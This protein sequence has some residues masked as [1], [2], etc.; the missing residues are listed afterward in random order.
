MSE[1]VVYS[2]DAEKVQRLMQAY[3]SSVKAEYLTL[4]HRDGSVIAEAGSFRGDPTPLAVLSTASFDSARQIGAMMGGETFQAVSYIGESRSVY[5]SPVD[6]TLILIQI[7]AGR[8]PNR[9]E[10]YN[11]MLVEKLLGAVPAFTQ[12]TSS[13]IR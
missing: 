10:D 2:G 8:L 4:C 9:I 11:R 5:I 7:F 13:L 1:F 12:N 6:K 3:L